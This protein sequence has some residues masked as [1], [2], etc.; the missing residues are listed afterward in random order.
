MHRGVQGYVVRGSGEELLMG[1][2]AKCM[3]SRFFIIDKVLSYFAV[4]LQNH[5]SQE[6]AII[7]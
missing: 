2:S 3:A 7:V 1:R 6:V 4:A 5:L